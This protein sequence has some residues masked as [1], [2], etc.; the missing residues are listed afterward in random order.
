MIPSAFGADCVLV[1][2][3]NLWVRDRALAVRRRSIQIY[4][5]VT[6]DCSICRIF[7]FSHLKNR[8]YL[9]VL[10]RKYNNS[11]VIRENG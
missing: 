6:E 9:E 4:F 8:I 1:C 5:N 11:I 7:L 2:R 10:S 3:L